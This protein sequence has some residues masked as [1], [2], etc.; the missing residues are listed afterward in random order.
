VQSAA[1]CSTLLSALKLARL[2]KDQQI[3][4]ICGAFSSLTVLTQHAV[5]QE[6]QALPFSQ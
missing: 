4:M 3:N 5:Q 2:R 6:L 1:N